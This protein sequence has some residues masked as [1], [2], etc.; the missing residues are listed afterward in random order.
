LGRRR[1]AALLDRQIDYDGD[2]RF[3]QQLRNGEHPRNLILVRPCL[4]SLLVRV[5]NSDNFDIGEQAA[6]SQ[7][8]FA[9]IS[10]ASDLLTRPFGGRGDEEK[11]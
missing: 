5:R 10:T 7:V 9:D 8:D 2:F 4:G 3:S 11:R 1:H 6:V